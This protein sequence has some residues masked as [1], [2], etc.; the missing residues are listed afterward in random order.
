MS[1]TLVSEQDQ[2]SVR[3]RR[4]RHM[5]RSKEGRTGQ[6]ST[7]CSSHSGRCGL[8]QP[9]SLPGTTLL[10]SATRSNQ[11][12]SSKPSSRSH[13]RSLI[14]VGGRWCDGGGGYPLGEPER[15]SLPVYVTD[16]AEDQRNGVFDFHIPSKIT[17]SFRATATRA[18][19]IPVRAAT[20]TPQA[21]IEDHRVVRPSSV[22]AAS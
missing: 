5:M 12:W 6:I 15:A 8:V 17:A 2:A 20:R 10:V 19:L 14:K 9:S 13:H 18:F 22:V 11:Q 1:T 3:D 21:L 7:T 4:C 16:A